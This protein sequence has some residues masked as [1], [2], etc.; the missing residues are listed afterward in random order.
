MQDPDDVRYWVISPEELA[1]QIV[2]V[3]DQPA[4]IAIADMTVRATGEDFVF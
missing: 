2:Y 1:A 4:G 3:I